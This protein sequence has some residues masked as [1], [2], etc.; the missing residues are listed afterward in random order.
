MTYFY[1]II[2]K[3]P[4]L[5][6]LVFFYQTI[7]FRDLG[8]AIIF[9]TVLI[10]LILFPFFHKG[11]KQQML[12]QRIQP[13]IKKIQET[14]KDDREK[15]ATALME[16]YKEHGVNPFSGIL[17]LFV[18]LPILIALYRIFLTDLPRGLQGGLYSFIQGPHSINATFLGLINLSVPNLVLVAAAAVAQYLQARL[19]IYRSPND[20]T[21]LS[22]AEKMARQMSFIGPLVTIFIFYKL[23]AAVSLY[24]FV[25]SLFSIGQQYFVNRNL[26]EKYGV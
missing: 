20:K 19:A 10:R 8:L 23:P 16:L 3:Q 13:H 7:A 15:Q 25:S 5:N 18:Q 11:A 2:F 4:I 9:V 17:L 6:L 22:Q 24:W 21:P 1:W 26:Q 14:H 12:M